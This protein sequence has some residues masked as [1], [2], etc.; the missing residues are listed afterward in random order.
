MEL[1]LRFETISGDGS[2]VHSF[3]VEPNYR[4]WS[5]AQYMKYWKRRRL[6]G[7]IP[8]GIPVG[9]DNRPE[10]HRE[11]VNLS[12]RVA[13]RL[14]APLSLYLEVPDPEMPLAA[15]LVREAGGAGFS[16]GQVALLRVE[17]GALLGDLVNRGVGGRG[18]LVSFYGA[19]GDQKAYVLQDSPKRDVSYDF[20]HSEF[21]DVFYV[22]HL[23]MD[24]PKF[25]GWSRQL[26]EQ[27]CTRIVLEEVRRTEGITIEI[28]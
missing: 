7:F 15:N 23:R 10:E 16:P 26:Q 1:R 3:V 4:K 9:F 20:L 19:P 21:A 2:A 8:V 28:V 27:E 12:A 24:K 25:E 14:T 18:T 5:D 11:F 17:D 13:C 22:F 6:F